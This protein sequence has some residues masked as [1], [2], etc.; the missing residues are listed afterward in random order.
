MSEDLLRAAT[1]ALREESAPADDSAR[2]TRA[3]VMASLHKRERRRSAKLAFLLPIAAVLVGSTA[4]GAAGGRLD[5][6][7]RR[8]VRVA[9]SSPG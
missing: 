8:Q 6:E 7:L 3:R 5:A 1:R 4:F 9:P 2:F